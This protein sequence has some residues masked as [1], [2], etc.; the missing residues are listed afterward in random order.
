MRLFRF[1]RALSGSRRAAGEVI[2]TLVGP[3]TAVS[4][5]E[6]GS[7]PHR[8]ASAAAPPNLVVRWEGVGGRFFVL[9][10]VSAD[11][12]ALA[13]PVPVPRPRQGPGLAGEAWGAAVPLLRPWHFS[14]SRP[15]S[16]RANRSPKGLGPPPRC[17]R[18]SCHGRSVAALLRLSTPLFLFLLLILGFSWEISWYFR[19]TPAMIC[20]CRWNPRWTALLVVPVTFSL[21]ACACL[22]RAQGARG[23][24]AHRRGAHGARSQGLQ[25]RRRRWR[26]LGPSESTRRRLHESFRAGRRPIV[27][28]LWCRWMRLLHYNRQKLKRNWSSRAGGVGGLLTLNR[29]GP[30]LESPSW[31]ISLCRCAL[32]ITTPTASRPPSTGS[33]PE[34]TQGTLRCFT[35][36]AYFCMPSP[37]A[38]PVLIACVLRH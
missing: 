7:G 2:V 20:C 9:A 35:S 26:A 25:R 28:P 13:R 31:Y 24:M 29:V 34:D 11:S 27:V 33:T 14:G 16:S 8:G 21:G 32:S 36:R 6:E 3:A 19:W 15:P 17:A 5:A 10:A 1:H 38:L 37:V 18:P 23:P 4:G 12:K 22:A 30:R